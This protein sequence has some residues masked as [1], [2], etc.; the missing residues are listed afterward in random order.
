MKK[1]LLVFVTI[2]FIMGMLIGSPVLA[3]TKDGF[4]KIDLI[5]LKRNPVDVEITSELENVAMEHR[6]QIKDFTKITDKKGYILMDI[7]KAKELVGQDLA[8]LYKVGIA[9]IN[10]DVKHKAIKYDESLNRYV[11]GKHYEKYYNVESKSS[12]SSF[13]TFGLDACNTTDYSKD[14]VK[15]ALGGI[16]GGAAGGPAGLV[17]GGILG[18]GAAAVGYVATCWW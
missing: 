17:S 16:L 15:G 18:G 12:G 2:W 13:Q 3:K 9:R 1:G 5:D 11:P 7:D 4:Q 10:N 8:N 6:N 14:V